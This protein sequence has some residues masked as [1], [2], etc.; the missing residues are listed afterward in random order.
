MIKIIIMAEIIIKTLF[1]SEYSGL[2]RKILNK[3]LI[4]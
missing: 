1:K 4:K 3:L 2:I